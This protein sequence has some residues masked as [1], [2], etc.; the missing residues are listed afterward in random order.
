MDK[1]V[2]INV[3][4]DENCEYE[5]STISQKINVPQQIVS[6][7]LS[8]SN[9][10]PNRYNN[11]YYFNDTVKLEATV[12][13]ISTN[14]QKG[15][16]E[17]YFTSNETNTTKLINKPSGLTKNCKLSKN[18]STYVLFK[19]TS[20]GAVFAKY[21][22]DDG[23]YQTQ[24]S[25][26]ANITLSPIPVKIEYTHTPEY[27]DDVHKEINIQVQVTENKNNNS[28]IKYGTVTF[29][30]YYDKDDTT[31]IP[32]VIGNPVPVINGYAE[33]NYIPIQTDDDTEIE[34]TKN[35]YEYIRASYNYGGKYVDSEKGAYQWKY[36]D[37]QS[38]WTKIR[39][40]ARNTINILAP[41]ATVTC[42]PIFLVFPGTYC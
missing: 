4:L 38:A 23:F 10:E 31:E 2:L 22:D 37:T 14:I 30:R 32:K 3:T 41:D 29:L 21:I 15:R 18:G 24:Q 5:S 8:V 39:I 27:I 9:N 33:I 42:S 34:S 40:L 25:E 13:Q 28:P 7:T 11:E 19:P 6:V 20:S 35:N 36:Y 26:I 17:F 16:I 12:K 1:E